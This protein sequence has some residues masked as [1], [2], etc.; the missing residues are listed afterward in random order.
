MVSWGTLNYGL[1]WWI[2]Y[3]LVIFYLQLRDAFPEFQIR[4]PGKR[5][6]KDNF[7]PGIADSENKKK[8]EE[9]LMYSCVV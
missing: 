2:V 3:Y 9:V 7:D 1:R 8:L 4:L 6:F 5:R